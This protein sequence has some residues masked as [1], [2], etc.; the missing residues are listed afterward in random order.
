MSHVE[1]FEGDVI[2]V[3]NLVC[4]VQRKQIRLRDESYLEVSF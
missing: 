2:K 3:V 1:L 4:V